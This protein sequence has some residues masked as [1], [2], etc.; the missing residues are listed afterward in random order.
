MYNGLELLI[1]FKNYLA[2]EDEFQSI[3][4]TL[5]EAGVKCD[6]NRIAKYAGLFQSSQILSGI[7]EQCREPLAASYDL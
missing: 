6:S 5:L 7:F 3:I 2:C 4:S 1:K